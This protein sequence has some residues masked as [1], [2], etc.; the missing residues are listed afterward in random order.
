VIAVDNALWNGKVAKASVVDA[1]TAAIRELNA[2]AKSDP[3]VSASL[4][5][6]GDG[7]LLIRKK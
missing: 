4:V 7:L 6:I 3:R 2:R 5:P 1:D